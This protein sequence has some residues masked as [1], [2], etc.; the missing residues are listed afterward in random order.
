MTLENYFEIYAY[1]TKKTTTRFSHVSMINKKR[2]QINVKIM[3]A[4]LQ[5]STYE[6]TLISRNSSD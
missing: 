1:C 5:N 2:L 4:P 3:I 6:Y